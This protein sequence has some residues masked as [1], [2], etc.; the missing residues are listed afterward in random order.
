MTWLVEDR[1]VHDRIAEQVAH[2][3]TERFEVISIEPRSQRCV[4]RL[5]PPSGMAEIKSEAVADF[6]PES[7]ADFPR[8]M[9]LRPVARTSR[10]A[11]LGVH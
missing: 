8:N 9:H 11:R 7:P 2:S 3:P 10:R 5:P 4:E 1:G 6:I